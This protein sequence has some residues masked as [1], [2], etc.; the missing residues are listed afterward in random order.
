MTFPTCFG[1]RALGC[2]L[3]FCAVLTFS[4]PVLQADEGT[5]Y[6]KPQP[7]PYVIGIEDSLRIV[8]WGE[9][10]LTV[11][12][13]VR[14]DGKISIPLVNDL[15]VMDK[16]PEEVRML[17]TEKLSAFVRDPNVTVI[18]D[19]ISSYKVYFLGQVRAQGAISFFRPTR[20]LQAIATAGGPTE[21]AS[22]E[23]VLLRETESGETRTKINFKKLLAGTGTED[24]FYL[25]P[26]DMLLFN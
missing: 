16:T 5:A 13:T 19:K 12:L 4:A 25:E 23:I 7:A 6:V 10:Q 26:G 17:L 20:L 11:G 2:A 21:F 1:G 14:P 18:V 8:V 9:P 24:N 3:A 22:N 15:L